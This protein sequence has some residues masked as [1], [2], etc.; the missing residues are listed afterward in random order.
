MD[1]DSIKRPR[2]PKTGAN[3]RKKSSVEKSFKIH[4]GM[5]Q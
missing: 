1:K 2:L 3:L 5:T 4:I